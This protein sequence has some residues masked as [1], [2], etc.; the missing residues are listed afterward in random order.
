MAIS[1]QF[2]FLNLKKE[3]RKKKCIDEVGGVEMKK[4][5]GVL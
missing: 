2:K 1:N 4:R 5:K 3:K